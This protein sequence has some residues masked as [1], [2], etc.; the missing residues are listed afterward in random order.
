MRAAALIVV[1]LGIISPAV[2]QSV[3]GSASS[4]DPFYIPDGS[5]LYST[6][7]AWNCNNP[8][9]AVDGRQ[10]RNL[11]INTGISNLVLFVMGQ[12]NNENEAPS[13]YSPTNGS[14]IDDFNIFN[15]AIYA[16]QDPHPGTSYLTNI[17][18]SNSGL[19]D[20]R[21]ADQLIT[22]GKFARVILVPMAFGGSASFN[23]SN[24]G[25][26]QN[27]PCVAMA[28]LKARGIV[29]GT[30]VT[31]AA[32]WGQGEADN[33]LGTSQANYQTYIG[34]VAA[35][36]SACGFVGRIFINVETWS[37]GVTSATIQAAQTALAGTTQ[38]NVSLKAG[39][40]LDTLNNSY[41]QDTTHFNDA[42]AIAGATLKYNA[43]DASGAPF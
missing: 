25:I 10:I 3:G 42:G 21:V 37:G 29:P 23:W 8:F 38:G 7:T 40:N 41:R 17:C 28:R 36:L 34:Q 19:M 35:N 24:G 2:G 5:E 4:P 32:D 33:T 27:V 18:C 16:A 12:S 14:A 15:G 11:T 39:A 26:Y 13:Q 9:R 30:N 22:N 43:W 20:F 31:F 1:L 6:C